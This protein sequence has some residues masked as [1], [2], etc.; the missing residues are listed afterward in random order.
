MKCIY[1][2]DWFIFLCARKSSVFTK[3]SISSFPTVD[4][5][6]HSYLSFFTNS[7]PTLCGDPTCNLATLTTTLRNMTSFQTCDKFSYP[8]DKGPNADIPISAQNFWSLIF[9]KTSDS[10]S[11]KDEFRR[12]ISI[13]TSKKSLVFHHFKYIKCHC[14]G[15]CEKESETGRNKMQLWDRDIV[16]DIQM[17]QAHSTERKER[18]TSLTIMNCT[19][20]KLMHQQKKDMQNKDKWIFI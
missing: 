11:V 20:D 9:Q 10:P 17:A 4:I 16:N 3:K 18:G 1:I 12:D 7:W 5:L 2:I 19:L 6:N 15:K 8:K 14:K 13:K